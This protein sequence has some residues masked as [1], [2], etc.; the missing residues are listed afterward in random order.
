MYRIMLLFALA[1][2]ILAWSC[3]PEVRQPKSP[4]FTVSFTCESMDSDPES[5]ATSVFAIINESKAK[6]AEIDNCSSIFPDSYEQFHIPDSALA[7][8]GGWRTG[9]GDFFYAVQE[10]DKIV[11]YRASIDDNGLENTYRYRPVASFANG[12]FSIEIPPGKA[13]LAGTYIFQSPDSAWVLFLG[14]KDEELEGQ[15]FEIEG[16]LPPANQL[17]QFLPAFEPVLLDS[18]RVDVKSLAFTS[19]IGPGKFRQEDGGMIVVFTEKRFPDGEALV[20]QRLQ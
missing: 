20:L 1:T 10:D 3:R 9:G 13:D 19:K 12:R 5:P 2:G 4:A 14:M 17:T 11:V 8:A 15:F 18:F 7:A 6:I 16:A